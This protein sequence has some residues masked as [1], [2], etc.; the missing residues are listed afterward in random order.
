M[1]TDSQTIN[2]DLEVL[3]VAIIL[4]AGVFSIIIDTLIRYSSLKYNLIHLQETERELKQLELPSGDN[5]Y[6]IGVVQEINSEVRSFFFKSSPTEYSLQRYAKRIVD[7]FNVELPTHATDSPTLAS[8]TVRLSASITITIFKNQMKPR[9]F[10][11]SWLNHLV[12]M[13]DLAH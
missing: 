2:M 6:W 12:Q 11:L 4:I 1:S 3:I 9:M 13:Y 7:E 5:E 8:I 10:T